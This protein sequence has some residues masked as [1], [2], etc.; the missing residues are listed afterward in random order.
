L[1]ELNELA[2]Q[3]E[4]LAG[5]LDILALSVDGLGDGR[6]SEA[7]AKA[8]V[9]KLQL[10][11]STGWATADSIGKFELIQ[12][13][14][15]EPIVPMA[16]PTSFL[17]NRRGE[18]AAVY[19]GPVSIQ[20]LLADLTRLDRDADGLREAS[21]PFEGRWLEQPVP[22]RLLPMVWDLIEGGWLDDGLALIA[23]RRNQLQHDREYAKLLA[24]T[25]YHLL[26]RG[27]VEQA[28]H[29]YRAAIERDPGTIVAHLNLAAALVRAGR[30]DDAIAQYREALRYGPRDVRLYNGLAWLLATAEDS[31]VRD[32]AQA[33]KLAEYA[34]RITGYR[35]Q[36]VLETLAAAQAE[37]GQFAAAVDTSQKARQLAR[38]A[39]DEAAAVRNDQRIEL[40]R[41]QRAY[42][43]IIAR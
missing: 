12:Q 1:Q 23:A 35:H 20:G 5:R 30:Y 22:F 34:A 40:Y 3:H 11:Y 32:G 2:Q 37:S 36:L 27:N 8:L 42:R 26:E 24:L 19:T 9:D 31:A 15:F 7:D 43:E 33:L 21:L 25:G 14:V 4:Q 17:I 41:Q 18:L 38:E 39:G 16:I 10:P 29:Q 28:I 6:G 13:H